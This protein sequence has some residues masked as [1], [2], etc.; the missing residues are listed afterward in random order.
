MI[1]SE[2]QQS[3]LAFRK[4]LLID[5]DQGPAPLASVA[6]PFQVT[7]F[8]ALDDGWRR[9]VF[10]ASITAKYQRAWIERGRGGSKTS[11]EAVMAAWAL[12]ASRRQ[13]CLIA[14]AADEDQ[15]RLLRNALGRLCYL[16][17]WLGSLLEVRALSV[18]NK[19]TGSTLE[20][21]SSDAPTSF[22][23]LTDAVIIDE[24]TCHRNRDLF[25][26]LFSSVAKRNTAVLVL[27][28]NAGVQQS[29]QWELREAIRNDPA[30]WYF[31][32]VGPPPWVSESMLA[33][34]QKLL[35][36][37]SYRRI[38]LSEW[39]SGGGDALTEADINHA[40]SSG[41]GPMERPESEWD[42]VAGLDLGILRNW[43]S[44]VIL[45]INRG[46]FGFGKIRCA[47]IRTWKPTAGAK[48]NVA[49]VEGTILEM[50][51]RFRLRQI[52]IDPW[53]ARALGQ[54]LSATGPA[55]AD[56]YLTKHHG[57]TTELAKKMRVVEVPPTA[58][59]LQRI[60]TAVIETF[61]DHRIELFDHVDLRRD[62]NRLMVEEARQ[63]FLSSRLATNCRWCAR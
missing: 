8:A 7:D 31:N 42:F 41:I 16:N 46:R 52:N 56:K 49:N 21:I 5:S 23:L 55:A 4:A 22:G 20:I 61:Q 48:V 62:L 1:L 33:Q 13:L 58:Q 29:F 19:H 36:N 34:Q 45:G 53:E 63:Q 18:V 57:Q 9:A 43:T 26:S 6:A 10:G 12:F 38:W 59:N 32:T 39:V 50:H 3:P 17:P 60:A 24:L 37:A 51:Q 27:L 30:T 15:A 44:L 35:P 14:A 47:A 25:D 28:M 11:D 2:L 54:R 40:F